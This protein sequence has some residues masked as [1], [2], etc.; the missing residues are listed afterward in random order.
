PPSPTNVAVDQMKK[1]AELAI[2]QAIILNDQVTQLQGTI[3][4]QKKREAPRSLITSNTALTL[5]E[6]QLHTPRQ[7]AGTPI[8]DAT[9]KTR[10]CGRCKEAG[11]NSR[12][13]KLDKE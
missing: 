12:T 13:C 2:Y 7:N 11:H 4:R 9:S 3:Q 10:R 6:G 8:P 5:A 1:C